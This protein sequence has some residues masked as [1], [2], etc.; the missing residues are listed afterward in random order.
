MRN[1]EFH[2]REY[3][4]LVA[5]ANAHLENAE[6]L[7]AFV[8]ATSE[9]GD[10]NALIGYNDDRASDVNL[11]ALIGILILL[12]AQAHDIHP[13][14]LGHLATDLAVENYEA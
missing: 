11:D 6:A 2:D 9:N 8:F 10:A 7:D 12:G 1:T 4:S 5:K 13:A 14:V 3:A